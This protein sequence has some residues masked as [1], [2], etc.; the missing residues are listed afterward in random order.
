MGKVI[1]VTSGKGGTGKST[2]CVGLARSL[3]LRG[4]RILLIDAD[5]G[6]RC[7]DLLLG[8]DSEL[9][10]DLSDIIG[11]RSV[12]DAVYASPKITGINLIPAPSKPGMLNA[13]AFGRLMNEIIPEYD[14]VIIDFPAGLDFSL[15]RVLPK[16]TRLIAVCSPDAV[17]VRDAAAV[18]SLAPRFEKEPVLIINRFIAEDVKKGAAGGID[19]IIDRSGFRLLG[20]VPESREL[21]HPAS[22]CSLDKKGK[23]QRAFN[24]IAARLSGER[25]RLPSPKKI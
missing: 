12:S 14:Y 3:A 18:C 8:I 11:G 17:A 4:N 15:Y 5:E 1:A 16:Q 23:A 25:I 2:F 13:A 19:E 10:F 24:R 7:L 22:I 9:V 21:A 20:I 6:L